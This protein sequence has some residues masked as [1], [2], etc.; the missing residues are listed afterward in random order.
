MTPLNEPM[1]AMEQEPETR[2]R[3]LYLLMVIAAVAVILF[4]II[5]IAAMLGYA[6]PAG[7]TGAAIPDREKAAPAAA[8][9]SIQTRAR[10]PD[11]GF[12]G[13][14]GHAAPSGASYPYSPSPAAA[15]EDHPPS[16]ANPPR[17]R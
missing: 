17:A 12:A 15:A 13:T 4:S 14:G 16:A 7:A 2:E 11:P 1:R 8:T 10:I 5:G 6:L 3:L 9:V